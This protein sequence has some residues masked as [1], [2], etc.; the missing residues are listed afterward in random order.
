MGEG[1]HDALRVLVISVG[2][3]E[4]IGPCALKVLGQ[5]EASY[6]PSSQSR[7]TSNKYNCYSF[8]RRSEV[9]LADVLV[10]LED[11]AASDGAAVLGADEDDRHLLSLLEGH[12]IVVELD[13]VHRV[14]GR[15]QALLEA[16]NCSRRCESSNRWVQ[17][18]GGSE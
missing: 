7:V 11:E 1:V 10:A 13:V 8:P 15:V 18:S 6:I 2:G 14:L 5:F 9:E 12:L 16:V 17:W 4:L 3:I